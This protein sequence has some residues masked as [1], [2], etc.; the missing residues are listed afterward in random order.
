MHQK[1]GGQDE[2]NYV[3]SSAEILTTDP[4]ILS[5]ENQVTS[6]VLLTTEKS[7]TWLLDSGT[8]YHV[9]PHRSQFRQ[10]WTSSKPNYDKLRI[11][12]CE[13][14]ALIPKDDR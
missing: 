6:E 7:S 10:Y 1:S 14:Y 11:F 9:T 8:S 12:R 13:A 4:N 2:V 3:G 5:I